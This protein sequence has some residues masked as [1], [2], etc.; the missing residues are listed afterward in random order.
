MAQAVGYVCPVNTC[1]R[2]Y[3]VKQAL[4]QHVNVHLSN[5]KTVPHSFCSEYNRFICNDCDKNF[6]TRRRHTCHES[7]SC[8]SLGASVLSNVTEKGESNLDTRT[9][10]AQE[11]CRQNL[12]EDVKSFQRGSV[13]YRIPKASRAQVA[14]ALCSLITVVYESN[15]IDAWR[16]LICFPSRCLSKPK[17]E[18]RKDR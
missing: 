9:F 7:E 10:V 16:R 1:N 14:F 8:R 5:G 3:H 17:E 4:F 15:T 6:S 2:E 12:L 18:K 13:I 11:D